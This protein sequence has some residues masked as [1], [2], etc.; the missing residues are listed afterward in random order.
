MCWKLYLFSS[1]NL[2]LYYFFPWLI[3][4]WGFKP[5]YTL[6]CSS[7]TL[8]PP[9]PCSHPSFSMPPPLP[10]HP[11]L[12]FLT[13]EMKKG[14][15]VYEKSDSMKYSNNSK[16]LGECCRRVYTQGALGGKGGEMI[17]S[18][19]QWWYQHLPSPFI[20]L[21]KPPHPRASQVYSVLCS[22]LIFNIL[23]CISKPD[24]L[25]TAWCCRKV[26]VLSFHPIILCLK[27]ELWD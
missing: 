2:Q 20:P 10:F 7:L 9:L 17:E 26:F 22:F 8:I 3:C 13:L 1:V 25:R 21:L 12:T 23:W 14:V 5:P 15:L 24:I 27:L 16:P 19:V 18:V 4:S 6:P 11:F